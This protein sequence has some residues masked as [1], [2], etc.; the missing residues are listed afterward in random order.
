MSLETP[1]AEGQLLHSVAMNGATEM[2]G[3]EANQHN[4]ATGFKLPPLSPPPASDI[5]V[6]SFLF[7]DCNSQNSA[8]GVSREVRR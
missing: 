3:T 7:S 1:K 6:C 8:W 4:H 2:A 5:E